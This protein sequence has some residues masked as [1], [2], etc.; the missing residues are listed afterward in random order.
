MYAQHNTLLRH[1]HT[2]RQLL[3]NSCGDAGD[4]AC[5]AT[6]NCVQ[7]HW[8]GCEPSSRR[9]GTRAEGQFGLQGTAPA[10][11]SVRSGLEDAV[12]ETWE[13]GFLPVHEGLAHGL[14][15][16]VGQESLPHANGPDP[17]ASVSISPAHSI[18]NPDSSYPDFEHHRGI[19]L[20]HIEHM[21][22]ADQTFDVHDEAF[23]KV[24]RSIK[25]TAEDAPLAP[26]VSSDM[27]NTLLK[28]FRGRPP[29]AVL[30]P[31]PPAAL[32]PVTHGEEK[33][34]EVW[35]PENETADDYAQRKSVE[36]LRVRPS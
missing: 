34:P 11:C 1:T 29:S 28:L 24:S 18:H 33:A 22:S 21:D 13:E 31:R 19:S 17:A 15:R 30:V 7:C 6:C 20:E 16:Y 8:T 12:K 27:R 4:A 32:S 26:P 9:H 2:A 5:T 35:V 25:S 3:P 23:N 36:K 10:L 14:T